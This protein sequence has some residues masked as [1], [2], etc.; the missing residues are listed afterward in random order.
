[1]LIVGSGYL[2]GI[3][4]G[5]WGQSSKV[6]QA[7][8][9]LSLI[10]TTIGSWTGKDAEISERVLEIGEILGYVD[11]RFRRDDGRELEL[12][13]LCG[14]SGPMS[15]H[16]PDVCLR[17]VGFEFVQQQRIVVA[18]DDM[19]PAE[20][21]AGDFILRTAAGVEEHTRL[22][23]AWMDESG[24]IMAPDTPRLTFSANDYLY[25]IYVV[26]NLRGP[27]EMIDE[28]NTGLS[29]LRELIPLLRVN[30]VPQT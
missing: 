24:A 26:P 22:F 14:R 5:R 4:T 20:V 15:V 18:S 2:H 28:D 27:V 3:M 12:L 13:L 25:K 9:R 16:P 7:A 1:M 30:L 6:Q 21:F 23:W 10:P 8:E 17:G 11:R 19:I 29:F